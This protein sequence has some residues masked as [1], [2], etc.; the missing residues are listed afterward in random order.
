MGK[1]AEVAGVVTCFEAGA[2][3]CGELFGHI[4]LQKQIAFVVTHKDIVPGRVGLDE[5]GFQ[6]QRFIITA[7]DFK[8]PLGNAVNE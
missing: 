2:T 5:A 7:D 1:G 8:V 6:Y 3:E 4:K